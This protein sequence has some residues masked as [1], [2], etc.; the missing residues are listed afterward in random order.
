LKTEEAIF[1]LLICF[2]CSNGAAFGDGEP[3]GGFQVRDT[4]QPVFDKVLSSKR[5]KLPKKAGG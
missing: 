5:V 2:E 3:I 1:E 4:P